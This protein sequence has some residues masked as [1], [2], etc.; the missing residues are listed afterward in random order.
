[1]AE[2]LIRGAPPAAIVLFTDGQ[3]TEGESLSK[4]AELAARKGVPLYTVGLGSPEPARDLELSE[5]LVDDVVFVDDAVRFQAKLSA[6]G[7]P[8]EKVTVRL[9]ER[10]PGSTDPKSD[11][12]LETKEIDAPRDGQPG[13]PSRT[14]SIQARCIVRDSAAM[15]DGSPPASIGAPCQALSQLPKMKGMSRQ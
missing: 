8:G 5:L 1:M 7:F 3:T 6:R 12:E 4:A 9:K 2:K 14:K 15:S 13:S 10:D 11:R